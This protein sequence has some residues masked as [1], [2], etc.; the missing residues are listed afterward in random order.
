MKIKLAAAAAT[1]ALGVA[2]SAASAGAAVVTYNFN[3]TTYGYTDTSGTA[4]PPIDPLNVD[5]DVTFD[6]TVDSTELVTF[7]QPLNTSFSSISNFI[8]SNSV[9][10][11]DFGLIGTSFIGG[12]L[13][14]L[15]IDYLYSTPTLVPGVYPFVPGYFDVG[16]YTLNVT[17]GGGDVFETESGSATITQVSSVPEPAA[18]A[19]MLVGFGGLGAALRG[20]RRHLSI[21]AA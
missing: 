3:V 2:L 12:V 9:D 19:M 14:E 13:K 15:E 1:I 16:I 5:F 7:V 8:F 20:S 18:W 17:S 21:P 6:P 10:F 11:Q 4:S